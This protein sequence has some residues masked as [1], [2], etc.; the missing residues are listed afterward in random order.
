MLHKMSKTEVDRSIC[1]DFY[2]K[3][4]QGDLRNM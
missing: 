2:G 3:D 4:G 1:P